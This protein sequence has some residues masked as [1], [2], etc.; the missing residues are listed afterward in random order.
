MFHEMR[1]KKQFLSQELTEEILE[2]G[3]T[4]ILA[5]SGTGDYPYAVP[6][7]FVYE[8][9]KIYLHCAKTGHKL[10]AIRRH[11][12]VSF[13]VIDKEEIIPEK[14]TTNFRSA[15]AFGQASEI[16]DDAEKLRVMRLL[17]SKYAP[18]LELEGEKEIHS[19]WQAL[20]V[21]VIQLDHV[22]GKEAMDLVKMRNGHN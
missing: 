3:V 7:N 22:T 19:A 12:K 15:I 10:D 21:I 14:F 1:R 9:G 5:V 18:G 16:E 13:C 8:T 20:A 6:L 2:R 11:N 17:N 4:G